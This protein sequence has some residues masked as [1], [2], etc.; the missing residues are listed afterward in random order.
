MSLSKFFHTPQ[1]IEKAGELDFLEGRKYFGKSALEYAQDN[2]EY[3]TTIEKNLRYFD[4]PSDADAVEKVV[5]NIGYHY[6]EKFLAFV[7]DPHFYPDFFKD[8]ACPKDTIFELLNNQEDRTPTLI[9]CTHYGAMPL[10]V[11]TFNYHNMA[12][13]AVVRFPSPEFKKQQ[14]DKLKQIRRT[15][16]SGRLT[17]IE[18]DDQMMTKVSS[19]IAQGRTLYTVI[20][21]HTASSRN[22]RFLGKEITGGA[23]VDSIIEMVGHDTIKVYFSI[24]VRE[25]DSYRLDIHKVD[26]KNTDYIQDIYSTY[27]QYV[28][29]AYEQWFF[30]QEVH[31][32]IPE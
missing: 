18:P 31:E 10:V 19:T 28:A 2:K 6:H 20:D 29:D 25:G 16:N 30:L 24:M 3:A 32:N 11:G 13:S 27:E 1:F 12:V 26:T 22:I 8:V 15:L 17:F 4:L 14:E 23:G 7:K 9:L 5:R 21:E